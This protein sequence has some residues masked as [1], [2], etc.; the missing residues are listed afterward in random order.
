MSKFY[1]RFTV[2]EGQFTGKQTVRLWN[3]HSGMFWRMLL[4]RTAKMRGRKYTQ[5]TQSD[6]LAARVSLSLWLLLEVFPSGSKSTRLVEAMAEVPSDSMSWFR[7]GELS[8]RW[9]KTVRLSCCPFEVNTSGFL[10]TFLR[11]WE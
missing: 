1:D 2:V 5:V 11:R 4:G 8:Q 6:L 3:L 9:T 7:K 10:L